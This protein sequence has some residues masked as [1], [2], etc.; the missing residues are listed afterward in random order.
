MCR[1]R[2]RNLRDQCQPVQSVK[3]ELPGIVDPF[4]MWLSREYGAAPP[5]VSA[6]FPQ[7][8]SF[9]AWQ[10]WLNQADY[11][12]LSIPLSDYIPWTPKLIAAF[13]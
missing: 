5:C 7:A 4:G 8:S 2:L 6:S 9:A 11:V 13:Q 1:V 3:F 12:V 10:G